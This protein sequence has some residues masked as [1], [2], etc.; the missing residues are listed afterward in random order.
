MQDLPG[1]AVRFVANSSGEKRFREQLERN[2]PAAQTLELKADAQVSS[3]G[4]YLFVQ[5]A[6]LA[7]VGVCLAPGGECDASAVSQNRWCC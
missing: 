6:S 4:K 2:C 3:A 1:R 7:R 5:I